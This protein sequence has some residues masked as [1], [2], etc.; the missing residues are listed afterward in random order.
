MNIGT[1]TQY[2]DFVKNL[3]YY[4]PVSSPNQLGGNIF[5]RNT[6][7]IIPVSYGTD[8]L[9]ADSLKVSVNNSAAPKP[10]MAGSSP[11]NSGDQNTIGPNFEQ[12]VYSVKYPI[13]NILLGGVITKGSSSWASMI[14]Y[15][16]ANTLNSGIIVYYPNT[17]ILKSAKITLDT[18]AKWQVNWDMYDY[19]AQNPVISS[20]NINGAPISLNIDRAV[21]WYD[22][23][24]KINKNT[25]GNKIQFLTSDNLF[26]YANKLDISF[27]ID[28]EAIY[29]LNDAQNSGNDLL[30]PLI[31]IKRI[32]NKIN[33]SGYM[34]TG[35]KYSNGLLNNTNNPNTN[36][37]A[38]LFYNQ[39]NLKS[40]TRDDEFSVNIINN[41]GTTRIDKLISWNQPP[42]NLIDKAD[43]FISPNEPAKLDFSMT[44]IYS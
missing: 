13:R 33:V 41:S 12:D 21:K 27:D 35:D 32:T 19:T 15:S 38:N 44:R 8:Y 7:R 39:S 22:I 9:Y 1:G 3:F 37:F 26:F 23:V 29:A 14:Y 36:K 20:D 30:L 40:I 25:L 34:P 28:Y 16:I 24:V 6:G 42:F 17:P 43:I 4:D 5:Y 31:N 2:K 18:N 10:M 11:I